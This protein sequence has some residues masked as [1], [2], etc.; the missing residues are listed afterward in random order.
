MKT[1]LHL[2]AQHGKLDICEM[3]L[4]MGANPLASDDVRPKQASNQSIDHSLKV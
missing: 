4:K 3:L 2:A 1:P